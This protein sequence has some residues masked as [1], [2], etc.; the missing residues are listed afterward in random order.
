MSKDVS[1]AK[2]VAYGKTILFYS[3]SSPLPLFSQL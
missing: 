3:A 1:L 2:F